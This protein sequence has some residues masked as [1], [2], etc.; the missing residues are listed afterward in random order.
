MLDIEYYTQ[1][2]QAVSKYN[3]IVI[4]NKSDV[5]DEFDYMIFIDTTQ[6]KRTFYQDLFKQACLDKKYEIAVH[7]AKNHL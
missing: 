1:E 7:V 6:F 4:D 2:L 3:K 5:F